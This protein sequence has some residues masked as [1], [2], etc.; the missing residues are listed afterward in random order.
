MPCF[1]AFRARYRAGM[2]RAGKNFA[3]PNIRDS[4]SCRGANKEGRANDCQ[5]LAETDDTVAAIQLAGRLL[6]LHRN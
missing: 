5:A 6:E 2:P 1:N 4:S 3:P